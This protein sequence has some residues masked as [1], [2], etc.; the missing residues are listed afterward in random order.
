M[1][2]GLRLR[3]VS[4]VHLHLRNRLTTSGGVGSP[5]R[6]IQTS[7]ESVNNDEQIRI[8]NGIE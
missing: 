8:C 2:F 7:S 3:V 5:M 1:T 6:K 4:L